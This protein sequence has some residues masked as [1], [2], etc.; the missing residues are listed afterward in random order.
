MRNEPALRIALVYAGL[1]LAY[2]FLSDWLVEHL[3]ANSSAGVIQTIKGAVFVSLS[4]LVIYLLIRAELRKQAWL[5]EVATRTQRLEAIGQFATVM[6]HDFNNMLMVV[7]GSMELSEDT[8]PQE[9]PARKHLANAMIAAEKAGGLTQ[10]MLVFSRQGH[11]RSKP[12]D[13]NQIARELTPLLNLAAGENISLCC[14]LSEG[15]PAVMAE[16][17]KFDNILLNLIVNARD[18]MPK[19]GDVVLETASERVES[20]LSED[21]WT[22]PPGD[23]VTVSVRD[24]GHGISKHNMKKVLEPFF[25]TK[26]VGKGTGL[27]LTT[28]HDSMQA[29]Q[30]HLMITS[31]DGLGTTVK[32]YLTPASHEDPASLM[33][34]RSDRTASSKGETI[35]L[36]E[37]AADVRSTVTDQLKSLGYQVRS[38]ASV[39]EAQEVLQEG[40][41]VDLLLSDI[42]LDR[43]KTGVALAKLARS[44]DKTLKIVLMSGHADPVLTAEMTNF[45]ELGWLAKPFGRSALNRELRKLLD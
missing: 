31:A 37:N 3:F 5:R 15:L 8:L 38:A 13:V 42:M 43:D 21:H 11:L 32:M 14:N 17:G 10:R 44:A 34:K 16:P 6:A 29:W 9:H 7:M 20:Q 27:G 25:T 40:P 26:P 39:P 33:E 22:V 28:L 45:A 30:S 4:A 36:V 2:I 24:T 41:K 1:S 35:L 18:A 23:Y 12:V 19:G